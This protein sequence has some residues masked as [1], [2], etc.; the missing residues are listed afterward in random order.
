MLAIAESWALDEHE[1][2]L[3]GLHLSLV[4]VVEELRGMSS[5]RQE[6]LLPSEPITGFKLVQRVD[7]TASGLYAA[8]IQEKSTR[9]HYVVF[10][11]ANRIGDFGD[12]IGYSMTGS[13]EQHSPQLFDEIMT[14]LGLLSERGL[15]S[16]SL[17]FIGHSLGGSLAMHAA[18]K[19]DR[20]TAYTVFNSLGLHQCI[21]GKDRD[22]LN[23]LNVRSKLD[24]LTTWNSVQRLT[25]PGKKIVIERAGFHRPHP[26]CRAL[27]QCVFPTWPEL[28]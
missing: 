6:D 20:P 23:G 12:G 17:Y 8:L 9:Q 24:W 3:V 28:E 22:V 7:H 25:V 21:S 2:K 13:S 16:D 19:W 14:E 27:D 11:G 26:M 1:S 18:M 10:S 5:Q 15:V 4:M